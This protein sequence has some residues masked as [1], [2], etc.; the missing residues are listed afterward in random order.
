M[1]TGIAART[2][3]TGSA[4]SPGGW[5]KVEEATMSFDHANHIWQD[6][7][8]RIDFVGAGDQAQDVAVELDLDSGRALLQLLASI[9]AEAERST[10]R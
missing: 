6:L 9:I 4:K 7:A 8:L 2:L 3:L 5:I 10:A 1:C